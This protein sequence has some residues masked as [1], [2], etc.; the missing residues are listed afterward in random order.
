MIH[1]LY[2]QI[3]FIKV[4]SFHIPVYLIKNTPACLIKDTNLENFGKTLKNSE[5]QL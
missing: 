4:A 5:K 3:F 2:L 1:R